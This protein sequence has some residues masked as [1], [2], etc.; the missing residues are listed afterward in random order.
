MRIPVLFVLAVLFVLPAAAETAPA[1]SGHPYFSDTIL[2]DQDGR[3][4]RF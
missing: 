4:V 3:E 1:G 2:L